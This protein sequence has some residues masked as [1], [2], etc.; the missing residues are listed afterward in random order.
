MWAKDDP[1][2]VSSTKEMCEEEESR[3]EAGASLKGLEKSCGACSECFGFLLKINKRTS[4]G[5]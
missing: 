3:D 5:V 1:S 2:E 4:K